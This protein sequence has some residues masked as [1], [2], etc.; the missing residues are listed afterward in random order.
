MEGICRDRYLELPITLFR[1][2]TCSMCYKYLFH[3]GSDLQPHSQQPWILVPSL[4]SDIYPGNFSVLADI[5]NETS[6]DVICY[7]LGDGDCK[8]WTDCCYAAVE[9]CRQQLSTP[10]LNVSARRYCP[11]TWDGYGCFGDTD[12]GTRTYITC[13]SY[14]QYSDESGSLCFCN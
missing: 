8:R 11:R 10:R 4:D 13:P 5:D 9:C 2:F 3:S 1:L 14:V 7:S 12:P 6:R